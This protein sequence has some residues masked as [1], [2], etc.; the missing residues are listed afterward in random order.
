[1][2]HVER[3]NS[4]IMKIQIVMGKNVGN[5]FSVYAPQIRRKKQKRK[6]S[7]VYWMM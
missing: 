1:M 2:M 5:I 6:V 4:Q 3:I 7:G